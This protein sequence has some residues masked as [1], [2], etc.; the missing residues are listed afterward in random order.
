[1]LCIVLAWEC[2][3]ARAAVRALARAPRCPGSQDTAVH[4]QVPCDA[5]SYSCPPQ[6][7][8]VHETRT[9]RKHVS[10]TALH[11]YM[12]SHEW[13]PL[14]D[15][16]SASNSCVHVYLTG[17][18]HASASS[19]QNVP[20]SDA[21]FIVVLLA[22]CGV[23]TSPRHQQPYR[24]G[25]QTS[26]C[27]VPLLQMLRYASEFCASVGYDQCVQTARTTRPPCHLVQLSTDRQ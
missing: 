22:A 8:K 3:Y 15:F 13:T 27:D 9:F 1:M 14:Q 7:C 19:T 18:W 23:A 5:G 10:S 24:R 4:A 17:A 26:I 21:H 25:Q 16:S 11:S 12:N 2:G 20:A 6:I